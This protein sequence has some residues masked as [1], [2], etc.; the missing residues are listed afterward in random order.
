MEKKF[1]DEIKIGI[2]DDYIRKNYG[3]KRP[4]DALCGRNCY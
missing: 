4:L 1:V 3:T 2:S